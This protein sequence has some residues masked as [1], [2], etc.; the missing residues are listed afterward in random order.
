M[1]VG[2]WVLE[3]A[4]AAAVADRLADQSSFV[5]IQVPTISA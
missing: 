3:T 2:S 1:G 4:L 5:T